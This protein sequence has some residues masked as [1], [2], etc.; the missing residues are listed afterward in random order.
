MHMKIKCLFSILLLCLNVIGFISCRDSSKYVFHYVCLDE[1][2]G[3]TLYL[4][5][6]TADRLKTDKDYGRNAIDSQIIRNGRVTFT[7]SI[8]T[9]HLYYVEGK[10]CNTY[11]YPEHGEITNKYMGA[12][13]YSN[14]KSLAKQYEYLRENGFPKDE[15]R[16]FM[17]SNLQ[18]AMGIHLLDYIGYYPNELNVIYDKSNI[19]MR[20]TVSLLISLKNQLSKTKELNKEDMYIDFKKSGFEQDSICFSDFFNKDKIVCLFFA[21]GDSI[22][23][24]KKMN[25]LKKTYNNVCFVGCSNKYFLDTDFISRL[26]TEYH[27]CLFDDRGIYEESVMYAYRMDYRTAINYYLIFSSNGRLVGKYIE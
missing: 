26:N 13:E 5:R 22:S 8:D 18:N 19:A 16:K 20:D 12:T 24:W 27:A 9:L 14:P 21:N 6:T 7:G 3:D 1:L 25:E 23:F 10:N 4:W 15:S 17:L 11:F 2:N